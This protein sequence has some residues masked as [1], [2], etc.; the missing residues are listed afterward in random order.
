MSS[1][2]AMEQ[3]I[4]KVVPF[5][6]DGGPRPA[7]QFEEEVVRALD[8]AQDKVPI[9]V[10]LRKVGGYSDEMKSLVKAVM[11][12]AHTGRIAVV[13]ASMKIQ[14]LVMGFT[15]TLSQLTV[16]AFRD[17]TKALNWLRKR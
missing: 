10:D 6:Q 7:G 11:R 9:L 15:K 2:G 13:C 14:L 17:E 5:P 16:D 1:M 4:L 3:G 8:G 12:H